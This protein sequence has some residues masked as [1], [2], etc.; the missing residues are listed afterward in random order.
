MTLAT[1]PDYRTR[2]GVPYLHDGRYFDSW[3]QA[4]AFDIWRGLRDE[5]AADMRARFAK[6]E[7]DRSRAVFVSDDRPLEC[8]P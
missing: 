8:W 3:E 6:E 5:T 2:D 7:A 1:R 4:E